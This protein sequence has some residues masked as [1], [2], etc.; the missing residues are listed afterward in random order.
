MTYLVL[1]EWHTCDLVAASATDKLKYIKN[2]DGVF[3]PREEGATGA[4][5]SVGVNAGRLGDR[6]PLPF[7]KL[8]KLA[9]QGASSAASHQE[10]GNGAGM[11][12]PLVWL[13]TWQSVVNKEL[14]PGG[15]RGG[16][17]RTAGRTSCTAV[18]GRLFSTGRRIHLSF[19]QEVLEISGVKFC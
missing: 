17:G 1:Q 19:P 6:Q 9:R 5:D 4:S 8:G 3:F 12:M 11:P 16:R 13:A 15:G 7:P 14:A 18:S 2:T 10:R